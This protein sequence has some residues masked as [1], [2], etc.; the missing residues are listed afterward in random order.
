MEK[1]VR[2]IGIHIRVHQDLFDVISTVERLQ[3]DV[4]QSFLIAESN[5][6]ISLHDKVI[7]EF[8]KAKQKRNFL[9]YVHAAYWSGLTDK[10]SKMFISLQKEAEYAQRL[11]SDGIVVHC[12]ST[13]SSSL[14]KRDHLAQVIDSINILN[15][16]YPNIRIL[17]ENTPHAGKSFGGNLEDFAMIMDRVEKKELV[18]FCVD[19][20]HAFVYG[21]D[22]F[23]EKGRIDFI[24]LVD[25]LLGRENIKLLHLN[26]SQDRCGSYIDKHEV[27]G[28][29][30]IGRK[31]LA[32]IM[33]DSVFQEVPIIMEMP[34]ACAKQD[35]EIIKLVRSWQD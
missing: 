7:Q 15:R 10:S 31:A 5:K 25:D 22:I 13:R 3:I 19:T 35:E 9:Y 27:P 24:K 28:D 23:Q 8:I 33:N 32:L 21:Y 2:P 16:A 1:M 14:L 29:G 20:A 11:Q 17:L 26:D 34:G 6:Y 30:L 12:G 4:A 18:G